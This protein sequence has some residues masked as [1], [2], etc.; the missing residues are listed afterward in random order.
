MKKKK[1]EIARKSY[2][3]HIWNEAFTFN[4]PAS[5]FN[6]SGLE[7]CKAKSYAWFFKSHILL[8]LYVLDNGSNEQDAIGSCGIGLDESIGKDDTL[9]RDHWKEMMHNP[10]KPISRW[11]PIIIN[12]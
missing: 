11:H 6:S 5:N 9:G 2:N 3:E 1:T 12:N 4:L 8:Q 7:V 10:R